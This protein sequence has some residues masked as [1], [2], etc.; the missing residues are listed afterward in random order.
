MF[1]FGKI[2]LNSVI[3]ILNKHKAKEAIELLRQHKA[4]F[5]YIWKQTGYIQKDLSDYEYHINGAASLILKKIQM[6]L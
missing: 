5:E 2:K 3:D 6:R 4:I 1:I